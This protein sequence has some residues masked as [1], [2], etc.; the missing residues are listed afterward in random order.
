M[1]VF[2]CCGSYNKCCNNL[3]ISV[4]AA[5][6]KLTII[7]FLFLKLLQGYTLGCQHI[8]YNQPGSDSHVL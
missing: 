6:K 2:A 4:F 8:V 5:N 1:C 3:Q 7:M